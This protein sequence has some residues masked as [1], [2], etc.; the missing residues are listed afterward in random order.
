MVAVN[1]APLSDLTDVTLFLLPARNFDNT[2]TLILPFGHVLIG[3]ASIQYV[4]LSFIVYEPTSP[5]DDGSGKC[6]I[7]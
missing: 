4:A 3:Y 5:L 1:S 2:S 7:Y 6:H